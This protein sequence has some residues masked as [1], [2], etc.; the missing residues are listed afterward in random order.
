MAVAHNESSCSVTD[1][2]KGFCCSMATPDLSQLG[3]MCVMCR[4]IPQGDLTGI[5]RHS[6]LCP[7]HITN[8]GNFHQAWTGRLHN[9]QH[10]ACQS[11]VPTLTRLVP[12]SARKSSLRMRMEQKGNSQTS[13]LQRFPQGVDFSGKALL[14]II[15][16]QNRFPCVG[17]HCCCQVSRDSDCHQRRLQSP[18]F[19]RPDVA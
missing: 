19:R 13:V 5:I 16:M 6:N 15:V 4:I 1:G 3:A 11:L 9:C 17:I 8:L 12:S 10:G 14:L 7:A 18:D 2:T